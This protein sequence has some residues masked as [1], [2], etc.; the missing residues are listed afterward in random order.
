MDFDDR[1]IK[2]ED[3]FYQEAATA[4]ADPTREGYTFAGWDQSFSSIT[5]AITVKATYTINM[6]SVTVIAEHGSIV[7]KDAAEN[8]VDLSEKVA[9]GTVL[10][11]TATPDEGYELDSWTN[12]NPET[13]LTVVDNVTV[14]ANFNLQTFQ[15]TFVDWDDTVLKEAQTVNYGEAAIAPADPKREGYKF[16]GWDKNFSSVKED[17]TIK[18]QYEKS[19]G[20]DN[21]FTGENATKVLI[22]G[23]I[24]IL[25]GDKTYTLQGQE[26]KYPLSIYR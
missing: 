13:G 25:R 12:Y 1:V 2:E 24:L 10:Y 8:V 18:A 9:Y 26:V 11:L 23:Q 3:V 7:A 20:I 17:M 15:V 22:N 14:T 5:S 19:E 6:Y 16:I 21:I 4:P